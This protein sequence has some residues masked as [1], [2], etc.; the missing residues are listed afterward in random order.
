MKT[1]EQAR[2]RL[3]ELT[4]DAGPLDFGHQ[5]I[6]IFLPEC[7]KPEYADE[8]LPLSKEAVVKEIK[9]YLPFAVGKA[10]DHRGISAQRS[11]Q[12]LREWLWLLDEHDLFRF[13]T[14][15]GSY[16]NYGMPILKRI[17][18][19]FAIAISTEAMNWQDGLPCRE[20]CD[21]GCGR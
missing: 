11:V 14:E 6:Q 10:L 3:K 20:G 4:K 19:R 18:V 5:A 1:I 12:K 16:K 8:H 9:D 13:A 7:Y 2:D 17:A 21:E 15:D